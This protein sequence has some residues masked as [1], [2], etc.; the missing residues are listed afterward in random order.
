[1]NPNLKKLIIPREHG[2]WGLTFE[3]LA[4]ALLAAYSFN[5]LVLFLSATAAFF[6]HPSARF[7]LSRAKRKRLA[8]SFFI[9]Y[10]TL[11]A[12]LFG[13]FVYR[14]SWPIY[15]PLLLALFLMSVYLVL[16]AFSFGRAL[17]TELTASLAVGLIALS[18]V[19]SAGWLWP[20]ALAFLLLVYLR[21]VSTTLY[22]HHRL[23]LEKKQLFS[24]GAASFWQL[25]AFGL[26]LIIWL[27]GYIP[28]LAFIAV[29]VLV[30]RALGGLSPKRKK[31]TVRKLGLLEFAYGVLFVILSAVGYWSGI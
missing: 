19:L 14:T 5:G 18:V 25:T 28:L 11:A 1:M 20:A 22:V 21:S 15:A 16:E 17:Y 6:A 8:V 27:K 12:L 4:L 26:A 3:P 10:G 29:S 30:L 31:V 23:K 9:S 7:L 13:Y 2:S 24:A